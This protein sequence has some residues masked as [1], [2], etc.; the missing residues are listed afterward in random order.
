M[1]CERKLYMVISMSIYDGY[2]G[3]YK[4]RRRFSKCIGRESSAWKATM[5]TVTPPTLTGFLSHLCIANMY[6]YIHVICSPFLV[7]YEHFAYIP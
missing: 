2:V 4:G 5:L 7:Y 3:I 1:I 6:P